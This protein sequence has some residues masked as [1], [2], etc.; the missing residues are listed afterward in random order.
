MGHESA[1]LR[2]H[3]REVRFGPRAARQ[4]CGEVRHRVALG[5]ADAAAA[6]HEAVVGGVEPC[7]VGLDVGA[8]EAVVLPGGRRDAVGVLLAEHAGGE[9]FAGPGFDFRALDGQLLA[10][11]GAV[12]AELLL[13]KE[14]PQQDVGGHVERLAEELREG[15]ETEVHEV[16]VD[17]HLVV[18][19]VVVEPLGDAAGRHAGAALGQHVGRDRRGEGPVLVDRA[20]AEHERHAQHFELVGGQQVE[21]N[22]VGEAEAP[23]GG[24]AQGVG[25]GGYGG[26]CHFLA[27]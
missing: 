2:A 9:A 16:A 25:Q 1:V 12:G 22:A 18:G 21:R 19:A 17:R 3:G 15:A 8:C 14:G 13:G 11:A 23:H 4:P 24:H 10:P 6:H 20:R 5:V 26:T 27:L 7:V